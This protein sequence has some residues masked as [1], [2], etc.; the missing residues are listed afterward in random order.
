MGFDKTYG[1]MTKI[2]HKTLDWIGGHFW[3]CYNAH[4]RKFILYFCR[5]SGVRVKC[6]DEPLTKKDLV[7]FAIQIARGMEYLA[8]RMVGIFS[9]ISWISV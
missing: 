6:D 8:S 7:R 2:V 3:L 4:Y 1:K 5:S 9:M